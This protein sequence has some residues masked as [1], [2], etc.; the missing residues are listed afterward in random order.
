MQ[1]NMPRIVRTGPRTVAVAAVAC[2]LALPMGGCLISSSSNR[3]VSGAV[4]D[5]QQLASVRL[6]EST[7]GDVERALGAPSLVGVDEDGREVWTYRWNE[8]VSSDGTVLL[9][10]SGS[11][12]RNTQRSVHVAFEDGV[13]SRVWQE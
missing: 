9:L 13:V 6:G 5:R 2:G 12:S 11:S 3:S 8:H 1:W 4:V 7:P 10:F